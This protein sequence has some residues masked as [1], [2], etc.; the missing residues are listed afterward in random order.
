M[1]TGGRKGFF[2]EVTTVQEKIKGLGALRAVPISSRAGAE[3]SWGKEK[4][5]D[6]AQ[7]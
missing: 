2:G 1:E 7:W 6:D 4:E 5:R 3:G